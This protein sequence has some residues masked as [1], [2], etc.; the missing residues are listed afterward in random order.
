MQH[1]GWQKACL[2]IKTAE[3]QVQVT[4]QPNLVIAI[5]FKVHKVQCNSQNTS[6]IHDNTNGSHH[7]CISERQWIS[8]QN[9]KRFSKVSQLHHVSGICSF[10]GYT[11]FS[12]VVKLGFFV[13][14]F[15]LQ[16]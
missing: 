10:L 16:N 12:V 2:D 11:C 6:Q 1:Y 13:S 8:E 5:M 15:Q 4:F 9:N 14:L 3:G 7:V